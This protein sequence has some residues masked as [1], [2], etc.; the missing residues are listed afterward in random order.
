MPEMSERRRYDAA[1]PL[2]SALDTVGERW[3]LLI[4]RELL[5]GPLRFSELKSTIH[6]INATILSRRL[7]QM[8]RDGL[9]RIVA[10]AGTTMGYAAT[11]QAE[12]LWPALLALAAW[13]GPSAS[14]GAEGLTPACAVLSLIALRGAPRLAVALVLDGQRLDWRPQERPFPT[15]TPGPV[16]LEV[17]CSAGLLFDLALGR[18]PLGPALS[19]GRLVLSGSPEAQAVFLDPLL[20]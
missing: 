14:E 17:R 4:L 15:R 1:C 3:T 2:A 8:A 18:C 20:R 16:D 19:E 7:E 9:V 10:L 6:G 13:G 12:G 11:D 5:P